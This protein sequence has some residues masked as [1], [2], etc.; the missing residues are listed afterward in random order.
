MANLP[1]FESEKQ[2]RNLLKNIIPCN[3]TLRALR[4]RVARYREQPTHGNPSQIFQLMALSKKFH[5]PNH[6]NPGSSHHQ[7]STVSNICPSNQSL[8]EP[9]HFLGHC[10]YLIKYWSESINQSMIPLTGELAIIL[11]G[12]WLGA[13]R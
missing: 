13:E 2:A 6:R 1:G 5:R 4:N 11:V 12:V 8:R 9:L 3:E 7:I 10:C